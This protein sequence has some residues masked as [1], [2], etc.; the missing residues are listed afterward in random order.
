[1]NILRLFSLFIAAF[2]AFAVQ[3]AK[4]DT[5]AIASKFVG[6]EPVK[7]IV[8]TP[9][10]ASN[11]RRCPTVYLL[12][13]Y[14]GDH[15][16]WLGMTQPRLPQLADEY[17]MIMVMPDGRDSWYW[18]S[19]QVPEM[20]MESFIMKEL[21]PYI[22]SRFPSIATPDQRAITGLSMG[23]QGALF[24]AMSHPSTFGS[25]GSTSG[26]VDITKFPKNWKMN[27]W[28]G[29]FDQNKQQW[30]DRS[31]VNLAKK[32]K[33][34]QLNIIFDCG[35]DDFFAEVNNNL[36]QALLDRGIDHDYISRPGKHTHLYWRNAIL[37]HLLFFNQAFNHSK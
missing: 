36:H 31:I 7:A 27:H 20:Q 37:Y 2:S 32:L 28:L 17:G 11:T 25:A 23:G 6:G 24:L 35:K 8:I 12:H 33:P 13:G 21:V 10:A 3:G 15:T 22:D 34:G 29:S 30:D 9:D 18:D 1:M 14:G 4:V 26:G 19:P 16:S 5:V